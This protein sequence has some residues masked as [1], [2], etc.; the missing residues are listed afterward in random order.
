MGIFKKK[1]KFP[2]I[3]LRNLIVG[4]L[5]ELGC[6]PE[7][8][9]HEYVIN[10]NV[11]FTYQGEHFMIRAEAE[12]CFSV[13]DLC[14]L[15]L[16]LDD[17][18]VSVLFYAIKEVNMYSTYTVTYWIDDNVVNVASRYRMIICFDEYGNPV[19]TAHA[20]GFVLGE[21]FR[22]QKYLKSEFA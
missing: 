20:L 13:Y 8:D 10:E 4:I 17:E 16:D 14:F 6:Q 22:T 12:G 3:Q 1:E 19:L 18:N 9:E 15:S 7:V 11:I 2:Y 21:S 5:K